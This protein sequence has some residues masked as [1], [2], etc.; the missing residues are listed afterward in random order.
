MG[1]THEVYAGPIVL[2]K[3]DHKYDLYELSEL[4]KEVLSVFGNE[5][6]GIAKQALRP[7]VDIS[8]IKG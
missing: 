7:N 8:H 2:L 1:Y 4:T 3:E 5:R 6:V